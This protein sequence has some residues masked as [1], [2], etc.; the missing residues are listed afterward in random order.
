ME[1][2]VVLGPMEGATINQDLV[3]KFSLG[4]GYYVSSI[5][6]ITN[7]QKYELENYFYIKEDGKLGI[8]E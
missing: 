6:I 1:D 8:A 4:H 3:G 7:A 2:S 5:A